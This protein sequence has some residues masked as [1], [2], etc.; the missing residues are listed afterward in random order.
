MA[1]AAWFERRREAMSDD[2]TD[3]LR[4][5]APRGVKERFDALESA[6]QGVSGKRV[7]RRDALGVAGLALLAAGGFARAAR[8]SSGIESDLVIYNWSQYDDPRTYKSFKK[9]FP[10]TAIHE[11][12]YS[13][14]DEL[15][16]KLQAGGSGYDIVVPSQNAVGELIELKKLLKLD[17]SLLPNYAGF[18]PAWKKTSYDPTDDYKVVKD[19]GITMF[20]YRNDIVKEK[21][22]TML[23]FYKLLPKYGKKGRTNLLD[24][25]EEVVPLALM[26]LGIDPNTDKASD[27][28]A[29]EKFLLSIRK[30]VTT[31]SASNIINDGSAGKIIL[32]QSWNGDLRRILAARK[33]QGDITGVIPH[34]MSEKWAD[35]WCVLANAKHPKAAHAWINYLLNPAVAAQEM[36]YHSYAIPIPK[37]IEFTPKAMRADP[38]FSV[39]TSYTNGYRFILNPT[40]DIVNKRTAIYTKFKA[41]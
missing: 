4:V 18:D 5:L 11:T 36:N 8:A 9:K 2:G 33:K 7:N 25:A 14:N 20:Y 28:K 39:P 38:M 26:A 34:G 10:G 1:T 35:N 16:A 29:V 6:V 23:D 13:S 3:G 15:L 21:P 19:Y 27:F 32:G 22:K 37:A 30:G 31:I 24:G 12:Y 40:P 41:S 17:K